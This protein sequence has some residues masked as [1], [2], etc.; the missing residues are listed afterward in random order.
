MDARS[1][2]WVLG[3]VDTSSLGFTLCNENVMLGAAGYS[4]S[5]PDSWTVRQPSRGWSAI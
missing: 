3:S 2:I 4:R 5:Y 1:L